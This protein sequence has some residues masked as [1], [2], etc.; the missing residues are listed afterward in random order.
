MRRR[1]DGFA[2]DPSPR[3]SL[4]DA[5]TPPRLSS[6]GVI[7]LRPHLLVVSHPGGLSGIMWSE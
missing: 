3:R 6:G 4:P 5:I 1:Y 2:T 7:A